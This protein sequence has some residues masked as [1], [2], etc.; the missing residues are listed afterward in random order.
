MYK[1][2][3]RK[4]IPVVSALVGE[5]AVLQAGHGITVSAL[6][7]I[8]DAGNGIN[9]TKANATGSAGSLLAGILAGAEASTIANVHVSAGIGA[10]AHLDVTENLEDSFVTVA[11]RAHNSVQAN[12]TGNSKGLFTGDG[13]AS[14]TKVRAIVH[15]EASAVV[16]NGATIGE[17]PVLQGN[18]KNVTIASAATSVIGSTAAG[19][20]GKNIAGSIRD[21]FSGE[22]SVPAIL[23]GGG[24]VVDFDIENVANTIAEKDPDEL[25][26]DTRNFIRNSPGIALAGAAV[27]GFVVARLVKSGLAPS[28]ETED[29]RD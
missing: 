21:L 5:L 2:P 8:D 4:T 24:S 17:S 15:T 28:D 22:I 7:N 6:Y 3:T 9:T 1:V 29:D 26:D 20:S 12:A 13:G 10:N 18:L 16:G 23:S 14:G 19:A 27:V 11:S 25:I